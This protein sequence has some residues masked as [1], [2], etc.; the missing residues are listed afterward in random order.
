M[1]VFVN[2]KSPRPR[3]FSPLFLKVGIRLPPDLFHAENLQASK[4]KKRNTEKPS[5]PIL[6]VFTSISKTKSKLSTKTCIRCK[7]IP[8]TCKILRE[9]D[10]VYRGSFRFR[11]ALFTRAQGVSF[12]PLSTPSGAH[13]TAIAFRCWSLWG[14][15]YTPMTQ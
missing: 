2:K 13:L 4:G 8:T 15:P 10:F 12:V 14:D 6:A 7:S 11:F 9:V 3:L 1:L 5:E